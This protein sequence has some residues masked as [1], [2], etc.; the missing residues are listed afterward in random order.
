VVRQGAR[1]HKIAPG[2]CVY[3]PPDEEHQFLNAGTET[4]RFLCLVPRS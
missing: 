4:L 1:E 3:V 2:N